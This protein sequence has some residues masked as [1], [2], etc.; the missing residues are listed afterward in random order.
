MSIRGDR[1]AG[2][3]PSGSAYRKRRTTM[4]SS[5]ALEDALNQ[6]GTEETKIEDDPFAEVQ[7]EAEE[8]RNQKLADDEDENPF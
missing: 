8:A 1:T 6:A 3:A 4:L 5:K 2:G 7:K